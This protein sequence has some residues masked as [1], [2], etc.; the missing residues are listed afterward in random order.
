MEKC[1]CGNNMSD[2]VRVWILKDTKDFTNRRLTINSCSKCGNRKIFLNQV[3]ISDNRVFINE[4]QGA[5]AVRMIARE[6]R[7]LDSEF[8]STSK[9]AFLGWLFGINKEIKTKNGKITQIRQ[10]SSDFNG[11]RELVKKIYTQK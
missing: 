10:Y 6:T 8:F 9:N 2:K 11:K 7:R 4:Y 5:E 3:R 1:K